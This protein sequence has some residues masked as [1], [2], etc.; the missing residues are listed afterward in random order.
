MRRQ[1]PTANCPRTPIAIARQR[2]YLTARNRGVGRF[3]ATRSGTP[4]SI[5]DIPDGL[6]HGFMMGSG[7]AASPAAALLEG[8]A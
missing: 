3:H 7:L 2:P 4:H 8:Q 5:P 6:P 1:L